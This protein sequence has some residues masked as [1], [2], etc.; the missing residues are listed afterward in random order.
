MNNIYASIRVG[1]SS[2]SNS[3]HFLDLLVELVQFSPTLGLK[4]GFIP[5]AGELVNK[6]SLYRK[7]TDL[8][9]ILHFASAHSW[10]IKVN[11]LFGQCVRIARLTNDPFSAGY[12]VRILL[13]VMR[14]FRG[15]PTRTF[16]RLRLRVLHWLVKHNIECTLRSDGEITTGSARV[17][18]PVTA[19]SIPFN[20]DDSVLRK[21]ITSFV[22]TLS[23]REKRYVGRIVMRVQ[24]APN[25]QRLLFK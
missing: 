11:T 12:N 24:C 22:D 1:E 9:A 25:L 23:M 6:V 2:I 4:L 3:V 15:L 17:R 5:K 18:S 7:P 21:T 16:R 20:V 10:S 8:I 19:L 13:E 14:K